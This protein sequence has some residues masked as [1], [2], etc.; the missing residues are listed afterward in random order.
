MFWFGHHFELPLLIQSFVMIIGMLIMMEICVRVRD[1]S[2]SYMISAIGVCTTNRRRRFLIGKLVNLTNNGLNS[3]D[4]DARISESMPIYSV[5]GTSPQQ[6]SIDSALDGRSLVSSTIS[7]SSSFA[8]YQ[9]SATT[10]TTLLTPATSTNIINT[11][12]I[13]SIASCSQSNN[14]S[15]SNKSD[16]SRSKNS[17]V[18]SY[19]SLS[20][21]CRASPVPSTDPFI[22]NNNSRNLKCEPHH[23]TNTVTNNSV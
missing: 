17:P 9:Q 10:S 15:N 21:Q 12:D 23:L 8:S 16:I 14:N 3:D 11:Q 13:I 5:L 6:N 2:S 19:E 18:L 20:Q 7:L 1:K 22:G 4:N